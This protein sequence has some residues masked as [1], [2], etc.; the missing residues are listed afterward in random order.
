MLANFTRLSA[1]PEDPTIPMYRLLGLLEAVIDQQ[2][3]L[4]EEIMDPGSQELHLRA[5]FTRAMK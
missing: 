4:I 3:R 1:E 2:A 5:V